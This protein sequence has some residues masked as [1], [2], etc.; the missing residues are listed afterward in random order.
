MLKAKG[1]DRLLRESSRGYNSPTF[2]NICSHLSIASRKHQN[3]G[4]NQNCHHAYPEFR[5]WR[6]GGP[7]SSRK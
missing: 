2:R 3:R 6:P 7:E 1:H 5:R 4:P